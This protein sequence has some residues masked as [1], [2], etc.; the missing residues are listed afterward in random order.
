MKKILIFLLLLLTL[1]GCGKKHCTS[2]FSDNMTENY[3]E[4]VKKCSTI[5][6]K[7]SDKN[8]ELLTTPNKDGKGF[9]AKIKYNNRDLKH[10]Y[11]DF[12]FNNSKINRYNNI[13]FL[14]LYDDR[15]YVTLIVFDMYGNISFEINN[16]SSP[17]VNGNNFTIKEYLLF[18]KSEKDSYMCENYKSTDRIAY[19]EKTYN[20]KNFT[21]VSEKEVKLKD[22]CK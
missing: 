15:D 2:T 12:E 20:M 16:T 14:E 11:E 22:I 1:T 7:N 19:I 5:S 4:D 9:T 17:S 10:S 8:I 6:Y 18:L 3:Y 13:N 21:L